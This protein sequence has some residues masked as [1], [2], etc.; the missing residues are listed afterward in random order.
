LRVVL[1]AIQGPDDQ[2][3]AV[4]DVPFNWDAELDIRSFREAAFADT[5]QTAQTNA[6]DAAALETLQSLGVR[7][8]R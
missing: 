3:S 2:R 7:S 8:A 1:A 6:N 4:Q 5:R